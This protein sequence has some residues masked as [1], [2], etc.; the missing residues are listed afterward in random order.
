MEAI[1]IT[2]A[3]VVG[4]LICFLLLAGAHV[5]AAFIFG[6]VAKNGMLAAAAYISVW[7][8]FFP[9][10]LAVCIVLGIVLMINHA[11]RQ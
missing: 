7:I 6:L 10:M 5:G 11:E 1:L 2:V 3:G 9:V 8:L 4:L